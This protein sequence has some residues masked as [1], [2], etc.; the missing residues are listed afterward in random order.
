MGNGKLLSQTNQVCAF[1]EYLECMESEAGVTHAK[2]A[3]DVLEAGINRKAFA[4][5]GPN[6]PD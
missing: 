2:V 1:R 6:G 4:G 3:K 5:S